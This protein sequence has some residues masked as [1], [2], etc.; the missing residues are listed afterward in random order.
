MLEVIRCERR[1]HF[2]S[3]FSLSGMAGYWKEEARFLKT[4]AGP[5][6]NALCANGPTAYF[7]AFRD[8]KPVFRAFT[9]IDFMY[10]QKTGEKN[11]RRRGNVG[12][13]GE[14]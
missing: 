1:G 12:R 14:I 9:G 7:L 2:R 3:F 4:Y 5:A 11:A 10:Q 6:L 8:G 13:L